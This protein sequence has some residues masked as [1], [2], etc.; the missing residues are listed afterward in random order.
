[1]VFRN[2]SKRTVRV[3]QLHWKI[4]AS[5]KNERN[6]SKRKNARNMDMAQMYKNK[7]VFEWQRKGNKSTMRDSENIKKFEIQS[8][9]SHY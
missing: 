6:K 4:K 8:R 5:N 2:T 1:M 3:S 7:Q 9:K